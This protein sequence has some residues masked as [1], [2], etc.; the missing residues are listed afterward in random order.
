MQLIENFQPT[1]FF[2]NRL[3][4]RLSAASK[5]Q[6]RG[7]ASQQSPNRKHRQG[8]SLVSHFVAHCSLHVRENYRL[9]ASTLPN[10]IAVFVT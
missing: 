9:A 7:L 4:C 5:K 10:M 8:V 6:P 2:S 1:A 3:D